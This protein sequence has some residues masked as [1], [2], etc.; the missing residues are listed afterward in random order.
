ME[1]REVRRSVWDLLNGMDG[2]EPLKQLFW[3]ELNYERI[4]TPLSRHNWPERANNALAE[5]P[6]LFAG[7]GDFHIIYNRLNRDRLLLGLERP[8]VNHL[9]KDHDR[10]LFIF[11]DIDQKHWHFVNAKYEIASKGRTAKRRI[12]RRIT[13]GPNE[14]LRTDVERISML[15]ISFIVPDL[16]G[17]T[18]LAIQQRHDEAFDVEAVT[19]EFFQKYKVIFK[20][21]QDQLSRQTADKEWAHFKFKCFFQV[22]SVFSSSS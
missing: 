13:V 20:E 17:L 18:A 14:R 15:D 6:I 4:N 3:T 1:D 11:S 7:Y 22:S 2:L 12:L 10:A 8:V 21:I 9:I 19:K 16:F 5:D